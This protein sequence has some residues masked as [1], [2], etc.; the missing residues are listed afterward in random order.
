[1]S[2]T[3]ATETAQ[4]YLTYP[5]AS[6]NCGMSQQT[7]RRMVEAGR[8]RAYRPTGGRKVVFDVRELDALVRGEAS[9][10]EPG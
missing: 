1:M 2:A 9:P 6:R 7:L 10:G 3:T 5:T 4:R 8:L